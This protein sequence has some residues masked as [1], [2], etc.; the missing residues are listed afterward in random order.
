[1]DRIVEELPPADEEGEEEEEEQIPGIAIV[2]RPNV[3]K[4]S[5]L[6]AILG[7]QRSIVS[8]VPGTTRDSIDTEIEFQG[9]K[10]CLID[11]AGIRRCGR[12]GSGIEKV[13]FVRAIRLV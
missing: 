2:G 1:L 11:T 5:L 8:E 10:L 13:M 9:Q 4:S 6:N 7:E 3:G 12:V